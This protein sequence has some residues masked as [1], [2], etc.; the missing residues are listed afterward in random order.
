MGKSISVSQL[1]DSGWSSDNDFP[2]TFNNLSLFFTCPVDTYTQIYLN[3]ALY[4]E[5]NSILILFH[6]L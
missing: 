3:M 1:F 6:V 2:S 4:W 5:K